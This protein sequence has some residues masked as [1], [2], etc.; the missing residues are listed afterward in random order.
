MSQNKSPNIQKFQKETDQ[1]IHQ[2]FLENA[3]WGIQI[4]SLKNGEIFYSVHPKKNLVPAS[5]LKIFTS[6]FALDQLGPDFQYTT[7]VY[8]HGRFEN[9]TAFTGNLIIRGMGDPTISGRY[10]DNKATKILEDWAD[11]LVERKIKIL[12][13]KVIGDDNFFGDDIL[14]KHW[15]WDEESYWY[16]AQVSGLTFNDNCVN[17]YVKPSRAGEAAVIQLVPATKYVT[18]YNQITTVAQA[19]ESKEIEFTRARS[20]NVIY[21]TG[22]IYANAETQAGFV[23]VENPTLYTATV[24]AEILQKKGISVDSGAA[25]IDSLPFYTYHDKDTTLTRI[26][27]YQSPKLQEMLKIVNKRS[28]NL[29]AEQL[30]RTVAAVKDSDGTGETAIKHEK[31]F[32][33]NNGINPDKMYIMDGS[34]YSRT[35]LV[36]PESIVAALKF[37]RQHKYW[38]VFYESLPKAGLERT[39][40]HRMKETP[41]E[42]NVRAKTGT[43]DNVSTIS[44]FVK[45]ADGEE[46]VFSILCNNFSTDPSEVQRIQDSILVKL[47][48]FSRN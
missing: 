5:N 44:G 46:L 28:Q 37:I 3:F 2:K 30:L 15:E 24:M 19:S 20:S 13:G 32:L 35:N 23:T 26:A 31:E 17:W 38:D 47:A 1:L 9:D 11:S 16:S 18:V 48:S 21:A 8:L 40:N 6:V 33:K 14:G 45:T 42:G 4:Q 29:F 43:M 39:L 22:Q 36:T 10:F 41:A 7:R 27:T 25:D 12:H 34:G